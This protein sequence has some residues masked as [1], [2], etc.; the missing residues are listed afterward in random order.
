VTGTRLGQTRTLRAAAEESIL[1]GEV[2]G[3]ATR[4]GV[5]RAGGNFEVTNMDIVTA[6]STDC[7]D[8]RAAFG[9]QF[10][11]CG[12][13]PLDNLERRAKLVA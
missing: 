12:G 4:Q 2:E 8:L 3:G 7:I 11:V 1:D 9:Q 5:V 10:F 13:R 6:K